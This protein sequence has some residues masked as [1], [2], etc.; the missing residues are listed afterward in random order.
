[1]RRLM[2][3][4]SGA[5]TIS[6][7]HTSVTPRR[8]NPPRESSIITVARGSRRRF[9]ALRVVRLVGLRI[10]SP[11]PRNH[12]ATRWTE[13]SASKVARFAIRRAS[14]RSSMRRQVT[15]LP[16]AGV[17]TVLFTCAGQRVDIVTAFGRAG[18]TTLAV[19]VS[20]LAPALYHADRRALVPR[21]DDHRYVER[22]R[23]LV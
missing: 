20:E 17:T 16:S 10:A 15:P 21:V 2:R 6:A 3:S 4:D 23:E 9:R 8:S 19:D 11:S 22:L 1:M 18:A 12:I 13:P 7:S 14:R 5:V